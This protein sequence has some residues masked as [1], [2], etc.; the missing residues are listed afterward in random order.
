MSSKL[1]PKVSFDDGWLKF[2]FDHWEY[3]YTIRFSGKPLILIESIY[4][5]I[6]DGKEDF[7][8]IYE[9]YKILSEKKR[10]DEITQQELNKLV[11]AN[12]LLAIVKAQEVLEYIGNAYSTIGKTPLVVYA[13]EF[14]DSKSS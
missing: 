10:K 8:E 11:D 3:H 9:E 1:I 4:Y 13:N 12:L 2:F 5:N 7:M 14:L 6:T